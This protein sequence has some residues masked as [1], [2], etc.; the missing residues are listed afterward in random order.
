[1]R[2]NDLL[3]Q[4]PVLAPNIEHSRVQHRT[5]VDAI[6]AGEPDAARASV[7]EH[8]QGTAALLRGFLS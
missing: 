4:I 1:M 8:L 3:D 6:L 5:I 7:D 2:I